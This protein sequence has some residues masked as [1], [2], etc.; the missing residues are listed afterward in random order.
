M[1]IPKGDYRADYRREHFVYRYY[2]AAGRLLYVGC[3][4]RPEKRLKE[5][6]Y[7]NAEM[8]SQIVKIRMQGPYNF[9]TARAIEYAALSNEYPAYGWTPQRQAEFTAKSRMYNA[10][11]LEA[12]DAGLSM[13]RAGQM[14][15]AYVDRNYSAEVAA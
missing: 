5:H 11:Y 13:E 15:S 6:K 9:K 8:H 7:G 4:M 12:R 10:A 1:S 14:A 3:S 2:D